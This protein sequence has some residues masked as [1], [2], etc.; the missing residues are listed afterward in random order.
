MNAVAPHLT[1]RDCNLH[2]LNAEQLR[3]FNTCGSRVLSRVAIL[4]LQYAPQ[5]NAWMPVI[6]IDKRPLNDPTR[7]V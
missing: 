1:P 4:G 7:L 6:E 5:A 2:P 3:E